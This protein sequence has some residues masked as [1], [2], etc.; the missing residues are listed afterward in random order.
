[1]VAV[2]DL[3]RDTAG[4]R[5]SALRT[6]RQY[7]ESRT[8]DVPIALG[9]AIPHLE[10]WLLDDEVAIRRDLGPAADVPLP[11]V[12]PAGPA[13][14]DE[15]LRRVGS[16]PDEPT[17]PH[18]ALGMCFTSSL[19]PG[20]RL[21]ES[22]RGPA[23]ETVEP[24]PRG[25][26]PDVSTRYPMSTPTSATRSAA[27]RPAIPSHS[28][29]PGEVA[30]LGQG[31][32]RPREVGGVEDP[33][34]VGVAGGAVGDPPG[35]AQQLACSEGG[36]QHL[37]RLVLAEGCHAARSGSA[38]RRRNRRRWRAGGTTGRR[39]RSRPPGSDRPGRATRFR[40]PRSLRSP[41]SGRRCGR[42]R[43]PA[44]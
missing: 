3:Y 21:R 20:G 2:L 10:A 13:I 11:N 23:R 6:G 22:S 4:A 29:R 35:D 41:R 36:D 7:E 43:T 15:D 12:A 14:D 28:V 27:S 32:H 5:L 34:A 37:P 44:E 26:D 30:R 24:S 40:A 42:T 39:C 1:M 17:S 31:P 16:S 9:E 18:S 8:S 25:A 19:N 33:L 38:A